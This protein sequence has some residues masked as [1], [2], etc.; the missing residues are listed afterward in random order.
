MRLVRS[1]LALFVV[2][3]VVTAQTEPAKKPAKL[4][5]DAAAVLRRAQAQAA[6]DGKL[7]LVHLGAPW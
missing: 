7:L 5:V 1:A 2:V 6:S 4:R 3:G